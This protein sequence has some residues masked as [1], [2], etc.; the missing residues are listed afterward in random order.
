MFLKLSAD[1]TENQEDNEDEK[2]RNTKL[3]NEL[4]LS[5]TKIYLRQYFKSYRTEKFFVPNIFV[6]ESS[7][8]R[9]KYDTL[10]ELVCEIQ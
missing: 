2:K 4:T 7:M 6:I 1:N 10:W 3:E 8:I 9:S 5:E